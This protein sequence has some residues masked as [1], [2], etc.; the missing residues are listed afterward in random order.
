MIAFPVLTV[1]VHP[2]D[3]LDDLDARRI[4]SRAVSP[5]EWPWMRITGTARGLPHQGG[6]L[7]GWQPQPWGDLAVLAGHGVV[8]SG[9]IIGR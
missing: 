8:L 9:H 6:S 2:D 4:L 1:L 3:Q 5:G 7:E